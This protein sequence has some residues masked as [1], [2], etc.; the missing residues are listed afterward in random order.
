MVYHLAAMSIVNEKSKWKKIRLGIL[1]GV[2]VLLSMLVLGLGVRHWISRISALPRQAAERAASQRAERRTRVSAVAPAPI[3]EAI[4]LIGSPSKRADGYPEQFVDAAALRSLLRYR[5]YRQLNAYFNELQSAFEADPRKEYWPLDA[6]RAFAS[7]EPALLAQLDAWAKATPDAYA[8]YLA[9]G[10]HWASVGWAQR[11]SAGTNKTH[12]DNFRTMHE[13]M[14]RALA[15]CDK[16][17]SIVPN[18]NAAHVEKLHTL[19]AM[20]RRKELDQVF[21]DATKV[22]P[23]CFEIR[24]VYSYGVGPRWGGSHALMEAV[25]RAAPVADNPRLRWLVGYPAWDRAS[26]M[27][28]DARA[29]AT[30]NEALRAGDDPR[31]L[32]ERCR[33]HLRMKNLPAALSDV[34]KALDLRPAWVRLLAHRAQVHARREAWEPAAHDLLAVLRIDPTHAQARRW[35]ETVVKGVVFDGWEHHKAG[36]EREALALLDLASDLDPTSKEVIERRVWIVAGGKEGTPEE[37]AKLEGAVQ[38][39]PDDFRAVQALDYALAKKGDFTR[40]VGLW[41]KFL[42]AHPDEGRAFLERGGAYLH[43]GKRN[44]AIADAKKA[45]ELGV[46]LGCEYA[47]RL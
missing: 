22:C 28:D 21:A 20:S 29:L 7:A 5:K 46:S 36:R 2:L 39:N 30:I 45:C 25:A 16:A 37:L 27:K 12:A 33:I 18:L 24:A 17:L 10:S 14:E 43:L 47:T 34:E 26:L 11:G 32:N 13:S 42:E 41:T 4:P 3:P 31:F 40:V 8:P 9:R 23:S 19:Y 1:F 6:A 44:E 38:D 15:D 35:H